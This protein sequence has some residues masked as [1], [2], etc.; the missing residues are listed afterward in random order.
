MEEVPM[1]LDRD[2]V[3]ALT[4][5]P[6]REPAMRDVWTDQYQ[7]HVIDLFHAAADDPPNVLSVF[8]EVQFVLFVIVYGKVEFCLEPGKYG[9]AIG[10]C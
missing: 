9:E 7:F 4:F 6:V 1:K 2:L 10:F 8:D 5:T 3:D